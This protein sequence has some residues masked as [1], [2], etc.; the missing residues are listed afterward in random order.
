MNNPDIDIIKEKFL[1]FMASLIESY[2]RKKVETEGRIEC[3]D[4]TES[5]L[6][7]INNSKEF[8]I[9]S[10]EEREE[11]KEKF[12]TIM[13]TILS[14]EEI[15]DILSN[16]RNLYY[17]NKLS[18][19]NIEA[20]MP[21]KKESE[22]KLNKF[23]DYLNRYIYKE[24]I[25]DLINISK[26]LDISLDKI[27]DLAT[28]I[29]LKTEI[30]DIDLLEK[31]IEQSALTDSEKE[32]LIIYLLN[33]NVRVYKTQLKEEL[34]PLTAFDEK[35]SDLEDLLESEETIKEIISIIED[36]PL[37]RVNIENYRLDDEYTPDI[38]EY[39]AYVRKVLTTY[40]KKYPNSTPEFAYKK[41]VSKNKR[42][43]LNE[44]KENTA[45]V[46]L[47]YLKSEEAPYV[48]KDSQELDKTSRKKVIETLESL[49]SNLI[50]PKKENKELIKSLTYGV[51][52]AVQNGIN[53]SY[54]PVTSYYDIV[55]GV[56]NKK[57]KEHEALIESRVEKEEDQIVL[58]MIDIMRE[59]N[60]DEINKKS[61]EDEKR[62]L[63]A[64]SRTRLPRRK[65]PE[66]E[67]LDDKKVL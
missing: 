51:H 64:L 21:Q 17:L 46:S 28:Q 62:V 4:Y 22:N 33:M 57:L 41:F 45:L 36:I 15:D 29:E 35:I 60:I 65:E 6:T 47:V 56:S 20:T 43:Y 30:T 66:I 53:I 37:S 2:T 39:L 54:I 9:A 58:L 32:S 24:N 18:D 31:L 52:T 1:S 5:L 19:V 26:G 55:I 13:S 12:I 3:L 23:I 10:I 14:K 40:L 11:E 44:S 8:F 16:I 63:S 25:N 49:R 50:H 7:S 42:E 27:N 48:E 67:I 34:V 38:D 61:I 59:E